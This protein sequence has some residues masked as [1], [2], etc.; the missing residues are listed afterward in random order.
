MDVRALQPLRGTR[1]PR[2]RERPRSA[3]TEDIFVEVEVSDSDDDD[4]DGYRREI[5]FGQGARGLT[6]SA[7]LF[8]A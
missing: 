7:S 1:R 4:D 6:L 2:E 3:R 5:E 8:F